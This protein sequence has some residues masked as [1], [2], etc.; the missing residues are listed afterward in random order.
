MAII[1]KDGKSVD[2]ELVDEEKD[3]GIYT[4][5]TNI[6]NI[7]EGKVLID[8]D[9]KRKDVCRN[10]EKGANKYELHKKQDK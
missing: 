10:G 4:N 9:K 7:E 5:I 1:K 6:Y 8:D 3:T 2:I